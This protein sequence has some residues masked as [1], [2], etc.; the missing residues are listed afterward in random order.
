[1]FHVEPSGPEERHRSPVLGCLG[2][3]IG[4]AAGRMVPWPGPATGQVAIGSAMV[5]QY[6]LDA[7]VLVLLPVDPRVVCPAPGPTA[8][9]RPVFMIA[10]AASRQLPGPVNCPND[11]TL[12]FAGFGVRGLSPFGV[13]I[14]Q[15][16]RL[17]DHAES[18]TRSETEILRSI[19][20]G[21]SG[22]FFAVPVPIPIA[23]S[24]RE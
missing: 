3:D 15:A 18:P 6:P 9:S 16:G 14:R 20:P 12:D 13:G 4:S 2:I 10:P 5:P 21:S 19:S 23:C 24:A 7:C 8:R 17:Q 1:M 11:V 22:E